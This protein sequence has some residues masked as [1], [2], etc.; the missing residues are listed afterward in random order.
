[1]VALRCAAT[2]LRVASSVTALCSV[3]LRDPALHPSS[4]FHSGGTTTQ[5]QAAAAAALCAAVGRVA[6]FSAPLCL[7]FSSL[8]PPLFCPFF[9]CCFC[10]H[11]FVQCE[12]EC[13]ED[14]GGVL[15]G[16]GEKE[17]GKGKG[18]GRQREKGKKEKE[19]KEAVTNNEAERKK[20]NAIRKQSN[21]R[22]KNL[23]VL[24]TFQCRSNSAS[25]SQTCTEKFQLLLLLFS[26]LFACTKIFFGAI[27]VV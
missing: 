18:V 23:T 14:D 13:E 25:K 1:V 19:K 17:K 9:C 26:S 6:L 7:L 10:C 12:E 20:Y 4:L 15:H 3:S 22:W 16:G 21:N 24:I 2:A 11:V 8:S 5:A 27:I